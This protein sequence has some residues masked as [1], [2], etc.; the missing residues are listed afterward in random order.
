MA[1]EI[2]TQS[3]I[4]PSLTTVARR[5]S[6]VGSSPQVRQTGASDSVS[7]SPRAAAA[8]MANQVQNIL[9]GLGFPVGGATATAQRSRAA[10]APAPQASRQSGSLLS[11]VTR[12][13]GQVADLALGLNPVTMP[14]VMSTRA[15]TLAGVRS[16]LITPDASS[17]LGAYAATSGNERGTTGRAA[18]NAI[19]GIYLALGTFGEDRIGD[20]F[21]SQPARQLFNQPLSNGSSRRLAEMEYAYW[22]NQR[23]QNGTAGG[24]LGSVF[25]PAARDTIQQFMGLI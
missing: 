7:L 5:Q 3:T 19:G 13:A 21:N 2:R 16:N 14:A 12:S 18:N 8:S 1:Q 4:R 11:R 22:R 9:S 17:R 15:M 20:V 24:Y 6:A 23:D 10:A 25:S